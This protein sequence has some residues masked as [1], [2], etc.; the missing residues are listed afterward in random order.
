MDH[1]R[2]EI[3]FHNYISK[4]INKKEY[5][6]FILMTQGSMNKRNLFKSVAHND[7]CRWLAILCTLHKTARLD[8]LSFQSQDM[9]TSFIY[10]YFLN[11][12]DIAEATS[13]IGV[14]E[15]ANPIWPV[16]AMMDIM[17][18]SKNCQIICNRFSVLP[19]MCK[20]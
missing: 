7:Y 13:K 4:L 5:T 12:E 20:S 15:Q 1:C 18:C 2:V 11:N 6:Y 14:F 10:L 19:N 8:G 17:S 3:R 16:S 9:Q